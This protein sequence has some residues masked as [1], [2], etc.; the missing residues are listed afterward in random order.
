[1]TFQEYINNPQ[2]KANAV[3][4]HRDMYRNMYIDKLNKIMVRENGKIDYTLYE[5]SN[6]YL[7]H[8]KV[9]SEVIDKFYYDTIIMFKKIENQRNL[10]NCDV[11]FFSNDPSFVFTFAHAFIKNKVFIDILEKK[12]SSLAVKERAI[13]KNPK[14]EIGYVKSIY[15]AY[16]MM[17]QR[18]LFNAIKYEAEKK[19]FSEKIL[20]SNI[21]HADE[22]VKLR[23][24]AQEE[25][26]KK[27]K[28]E[29]NRPSTKPERRDIIHPS[30]GYIDTNIKNTISIKHTST[31]NKTKNIATSKQIRKTKK[32]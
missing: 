23:Q 5:T 20:L 2:G 1:M 13:E 29:E 12:M 14:D 25:L 28:K 9:P 18:G 24:E 15:F 16:L 17:S 27:N 8:M 3:F 21:M 26:S 30:S 22:K 11:K 7:C 32:V 10:L 19:P 6:F 4:S 31:I